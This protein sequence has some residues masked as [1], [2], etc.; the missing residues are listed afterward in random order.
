MPPSLRTNSSIHPTPQP[1][2]S[3]LFYSYNVGGVHVIALSA[4]SDY[5]ATG[6]M[7]SFLRADLSAVDRAVTPWV[8]AVWVR[9]RGRRAG[10][11]R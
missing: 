6:P 8:I 4:Y 7:V 1:L 3:P 11:P 5:S 9:G 10:A 2:R